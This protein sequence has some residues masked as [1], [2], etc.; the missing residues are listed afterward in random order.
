MAARAGRVLEGMLAR[1]L[2]TIC[3]VGGGDVGLARAVEEG[4]FTGPRIRYGGMQLTQTGGAGDWRAP[5]RQ[6]NHDN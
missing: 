4:Y 3:D 1:G 6:V 5:S 2:T